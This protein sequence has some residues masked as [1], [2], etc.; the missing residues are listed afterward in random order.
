MGMGGGG[1]R[2]MRCSAAARPLVGIEVPPW[3][4]RDGAG[5]T[6]RPGLLIFPPLP[7][8]RLQDFLQGGTSPASSRCWTNPLPGLTRL[9]ER[10]WGG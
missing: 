1:T 9:R 2:R 7:R 6:G 5:A 4:L 8:R 10:F 3:R